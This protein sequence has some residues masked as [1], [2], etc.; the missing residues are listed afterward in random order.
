MNNG[1]NIATTKSGTTIDA[2]FSRNLHHLESRTYVSYFS[3]HKALISA[4]P[5]PAPIEDNVQI[6]EIN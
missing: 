1:R 5:I 3:Y 6:E 2:I 4:T